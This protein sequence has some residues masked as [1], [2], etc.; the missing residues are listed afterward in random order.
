MSIPLTQLGPLIAA[1]TPVGGLIFQIGKHSE[2]LDI[3]GL[4]V[5]AQEK[6]EEHTISSINDIKSAI[7][8]LQMDVSYIKEDVHDI[9][10]TIHQ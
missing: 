6:K 2:K 3:M 8:V 4:K 9:K 7:Q 1:T 5:E 10:S